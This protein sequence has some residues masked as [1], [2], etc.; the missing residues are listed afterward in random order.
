MNI[1]VTGGTGFIGNYL[2]RGLVAEGH[3][4]RCLVRDL[5]S[6]NKLADHSQVDFVEG[7]VAMI[8]TLENIGKGIEAVY[9]LAGA[10][11]V[12]AVSKEAFQ[13]FF[14]LNVRGT[15]NIMEA[16]G[17][18]GVKRFIHFSSTAAMGLT[19]R[20]EID[21]TVP[22]EPETPYQRSKYQSELAAFET[23]KKLGLEV[24]I[25]R[26]CMVYGPGGKGEFLKFCRLIKK[27][28]FPRVGT[29]KNLTPMVHVQDVA[30]AAIRALQSGRSGEVYLIASETSPP[31][32]EIHRLVTRT[33]GTRRPYFY[34]PLPVA[35]LAAYLLEKWAFLNK[36]TPVVS[37]K[38]ILSFATGRVF[39]TL[40]ASDDLRYV[41]TQK[42]ESGIEETIRW[43]QQMKLL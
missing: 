18:S 3:R 8:E 9:H 15:R 20:R 12:S 5:H 2:V 27:G 13:S 41:P 16:C 42:L 6:I 14:R 31:F 36:V 7:D 24:I 35:L 30:Q 22:C 28:V 25:L 1:L 32:K 10:G 33:L 40:K 23:G 38:N 37:R 26:P 4:C 17:R 21:E 39:S 34:V 19:R 29:G 43:Y 11:H